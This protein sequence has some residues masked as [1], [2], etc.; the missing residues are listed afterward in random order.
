[1][2]LDWSNSASESIRTDYN[3][4]ARYLVELSQLVPSLVIQHMIDKTQNA[5]GQLSL[6]SH[7][8][9]DEP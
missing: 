8:V 4:K 5:S 7:S 3:V 2:A 6:P 1:M 9:I